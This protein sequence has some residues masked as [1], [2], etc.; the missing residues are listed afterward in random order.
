VQIGNGYNGGSSLPFLPMKVI[1]VILQHVPLT[2]RLT[3]CA[4]VC[5]AWADAAASLSVHVEHQVRPEY[6]SAFIPWL[7]QHGH[8]LCSLQLQSS[9]GLSEQLPLLQLPPSLQRLD[10][11]H[12]KKL[13][14]ALPAPQHSTAAGGSLAA[15][16]TASGAAGAVA[17]LPRLRELKLQSCSVDA[18][19][20]IVRLTAASSIT[21]LELGCVRFLDLAGD[22]LYSAGWPMESLLRVQEAVSEMLQQLPDLRVLRLNHALLCPAAVQQVSAMP[23]LRELSIEMPYHSID[24][25]AASLPSTLSWCVAS[26]SRRPLMTW[27][28]PSRPSCR[29]CMRCHTCWSWT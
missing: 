23:C 15:A 27:S 3:A 12:L 2:E 17:L 25:A 6:L 24:G 29:A 4:L 1:E 11:L 20:S 18:L 5:K 10:C 22:T 21:R 14:L 19:D 8:R 7:E 9:Y 13:S 26:R 28:K 16:R